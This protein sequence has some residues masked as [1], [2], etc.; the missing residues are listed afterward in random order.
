MAHKKTNWQYLKQRLAQSSFRSRFRL[1]VEEQEYVNVKGMDT[2]RQHAFEF[3][4]KR[5]AP[6]FPVKD[7]Q[8]TPLRG[9]PIF[10]AQH[11]TG[12]CC[13]GCLQKWHGIAPGIQLTEEDI[14]YIVAVLIAWIQDQM[15]NN[16]CP[17][18]NIHEDQSEQLHLFERD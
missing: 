8:Q 2:L 6:A 16:S 11:A 5:L 3:I 14:D 10:I 9:H 18:E 15:S 17:L 12:T 7:G 4:R 13:R 1:G